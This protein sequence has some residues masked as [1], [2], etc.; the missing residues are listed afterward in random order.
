MILSSARHIQS[1]SSTFTRLAGYCNL[2]CRFTA[3]KIVT[4]GKLSV[5]RSLSPQSQFKLRDWS[6]A[7]PAKSPDA[8]HPVVGRTAERT[9]AERRRRVSCSKQPQPRAIG[10][11]RRVEMLVQAWYA[12]AGSPDCE[13]RLVCLL[14]PTCAGVEWWSA[15]CCLYTIASGTGWFL[16][17]GGQSF[18]CNWDRRGDNFSGLITFCFLDY[19]PAQSDQHRGRNASPHH[20]H[21]QTQCGEHTTYQAG[22]S[23]DHQITPDD[24]IVGRST[25]LSTLFPQIR[26]KH[27]HNCGFSIDIIA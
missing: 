17:N 14:F 18:I 9:A 11:L 10:L 6:P 1:H 27:R 5:S 7:S 8:R 16:A 22:S 26:T 20:P 19:A 3:H 2:A 12:V 4:R 24:L 13:P 23:P 15:L 25:A 21:V